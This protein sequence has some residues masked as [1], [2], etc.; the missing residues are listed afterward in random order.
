M[1][2]E[3][4]PSVECLN[5]FVIIT[6]YEGPLYNNENYTKFKKMPNKVLAQTQFYKIYNVTYTYIANSTLIVRFID[7]FNSVL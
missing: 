2:G 4:F 1:T 5:I 7:I 3:Y 6:Q